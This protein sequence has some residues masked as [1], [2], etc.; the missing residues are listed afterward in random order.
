MKLT[1]KI[2][3]LVL[4]YQGISVPCPVNE[5]H[6]MIPVKTVCQIID[7]DFQKQDSW[8]KKHEIFSQLY[9]LGYT[10]GADNKRREM[11][12]LPMFD[13]Y[14]W[15]SSISDNQRKE[16]STD[17]QYAFMVWLRSQM[18]DLY[19]S[20]EIYIAENQYEQ[21]LVSEKERIEAE[22]LEASHNVKEL[23]ARLKTIEDTIEDIRIN[24]FTG[25]TALP[26]PEN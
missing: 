12:C 7:V 25:Q 19:K 4:D 2:S 16:G 1:P 15:L 22:I 18:L 3:E 9:T 13:L 20:I 21:D 10:V 24:R 17:K 6:H 5:G 26:F 23:K 14:A 8:L 11:N